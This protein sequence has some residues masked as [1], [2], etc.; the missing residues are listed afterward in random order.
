M[1]KARL[2]KVASDFRV[3]WG[4]TLL[5]L[6]GLSLGLFGL[7]AVVT[8]FAIIANDLD[9]NFERTNPPNVVIAAD[10]VSEAAIRRLR[11]IE[12]VTGVDDRPMVAG[13]LEVGVGQWMPIMVH[14]VADFD[15]MPTARIFP[16]SGPWPPST[17][18]LLVERS[19]RFWVRGSTGA[20]LR[21]RLGAGRPFTARLGGF[22]FDPGQ[23]PSPMDRVIY[24][25][26]TP[27]TWNTWTGQPPVSRLLLKVDTRST[28]AADVAGAAQSMLRAGGADVRRVQSFEHPAHPHQFQLNSFVAMLGAL[29]LFSFLMCAVLIVNLIDSVMANE[30]RSIGVMRALGARRRQIASD[31]LF[32]MGLLGLAAGALV[33]PFALPTGR[34]I[35][36]FIAMAVN[37]DLLSP[38]GPRWLIPFILGLAFLLPVSVALY[39]VLRASRMPVRE[40]LSRLEPGRN[41]RRSE[42][43]GALLRPFPL[44]Q[45]IAIRSLSRRPWRALL[46]SAILALGVAFFMMALNVRSSMLATVDTVERTKPHD[47]A[48]TLRQSYPNDQIAS[49]LGDFPSISSWEYWAVSEGNLQRPGGQAVNPMA[50]YFIPGTSIAFRPDVLA[51]QWLQPGRA[52]GIVVTQAVVDANPFIQVG[53]EFVLR[54]NERSTPVEIIGVVKEFGEGRLY[55][56][57]ALHEALGQPAARSNHIIITLTD[58]SASAQTG[59]IA[60]LEESIVASDWEIAAAMGTRMWEQII[61]AHLVDI[62]RLFSVIAGIAL[63]IGAMGLASSISVGVVERYREIAVLKAIGGRSRAVATIFVSEALLIALVGTCFAL[64]IAPWLSR[65]AADKFG[66]LMIEY[67]FDYRAADNVGFL[68]LAVAL[69]IALLACIFPVRTALRMTIRKAL[70]TE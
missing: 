69:L 20:E 56:P 30:Q 70:R 29:G 54:L 67:P 31:Y 45:R 13:R 43:F 5:S 59:A 24:A 27:Q 26:V 34:G 61:L 65:A 37:F 14:V 16:Q 22:A 11:T 64:L 38:G 42:R 7:A 23:A 44:L 3:R 58:H 49:W 10:R 60:E 50:V 33:L 48:L 66:T 4:R 62:G 46:T 1:T 68:A 15:R 9:E 35:A 63:F 51:G 55:A 21:L 19:G 53:A 17:G 47:L 40:A 52:N 28:S 25:Y 32:A 6:I 8:A 2:R 12:G 57:L 39:R 18:S 41:G 36:G